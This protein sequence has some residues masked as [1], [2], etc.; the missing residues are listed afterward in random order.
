MSYQ[1]LL[2][3]MIGMALFLAGCTAPAATYTPPPTF[4]PPPLPTPTLIPPPPQ[5]VQPTGQAGT[6]PENDTSPLGVIRSTDHGTTWTSLG[7]AC[8]QNSTVWAVD[9]TPLTINGTIVLYSV[10]FH[11]LDKAVLYRTTSGDGINFDTPQP[12]YTHTNAIVDPFVLLMPDGSFR[13]Y[14]TGQDGIFS[15][16]SSDGLTFIREEGVRSRGGGMPG[17]LLLPDNRVRLFLSGD[18]IM[19]F[20]SSDGLSF[21]QESGMRIPAPPNTIVDNPEP[22]RLSDGSYLMLFSLHSKMYEGQLPWEHTEIR[23]A[24]STDG[25]N[26]TVNPTVLGYGGTSCVVE[27]QDGTLFIYYVNQ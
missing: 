5:L 25:L 11:H 21:T 4:P 1:K 20:I 27:V 7:N 22:I 3:Q 13:L 15:A 10:D 19:S 18:G 16:V 2:M 26:W 17:A 9:P 8:M 14:T 12:V 23:L 24:A 6:C